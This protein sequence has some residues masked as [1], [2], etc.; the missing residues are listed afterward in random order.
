MLSKVLSDPPPLLSVE[1][2]VL[3]CEIVADLLM[4]AD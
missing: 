2:N 3:S 4:P 1:V